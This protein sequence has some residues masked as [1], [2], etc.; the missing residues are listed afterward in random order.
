MDFV[1]LG[2]LQ[3]LDEGR[4]VT[5]AGSKRR[6]L[7][8]LLL[9]HANETVSTERL[10]DELWAER[11]P[12]T[13]ARTL[14]AHISRLRKALKAGAADPDG[15]IVTRESGY[16]L[17]LDPERL[18]AYQFERLVD[19]GRNELASGRA[20]RAVSGYEAALS[21]WR[22]T[23]LADFAS[24]QFAQGEIARLEDLRMAAI[25]GL[26]DAKLALGR[27]AELVGQLESLIGENP[28]RERLRAQLMLALYRCER[29]ADAL[30]AYQ[31]ARRTLVEDLGIEPGE[32]LRDLEHA[33]LSQDPAL[34][35]AVAETAE[36]AAARVPP[37]PNRTLGRDQ[38]REEVR[39][40]LRRDDRRLVTLVGPGGVGKTRLA[41]EAARRLEPD[42]RDGAW[43]VSLASTANPEHVPSA[44]AQTLGAT[45]LEGETPEQAIERFL[46]PKDALLVL[47]NFEHVLPAAPLITELLAAAP[48][49][50]VLATSREPLRLQTEYCYAVAPLEVPADTDPAAVTH[51]AAG[52]L[53]V[54]RAGS[55]DR[56]FELNPGNAG[57]IAEI[58]QRLDGLPLAI[59]LAAAR[60]TVLAPED[61][62]ARLEG[63]LDLLGHGPR[64]AP[65]RQRTLRATIEWSHDLLSAAESEAFAGL[66]VFAGGATTDAA[67]TITGAE[68]EAL[69]GLIDKQLLVRRHGAGGDARLWMLETVREF[70]REQLEADP[71]AD[72]V[73]HS[74]C[75]YYLALAERAEPHLFTRREDE[76]L[77]KLDAEG[78]NF[79]AA[80][81]WSIRHG[82]PNHGLQLAGL[83]GRYWDVRNLAPEGLD[84]LEAAIA[85]AGDEA[86][87]RDRALARRAQ[88]HLLVDQGAAYDTHDLHDDAKSKAAEALALSREAAEPAGVTD[89]LLAMASLDMAESHPQRRRRALANE[90]LAYARVAA[91]ERFV[92]LA[93]M[94]QANAISL[95][96]AAEEIE[97]ATT[98]LRKLGCSRILVAHYNNTAYNAIKVGRPER[99]RAF[100][101]EA[102]PLAHEVGFPVFVALTSGNEALEALFTGD[103]D[104]AR[105][106]FEEELRVCREHVVHQFV[107]EGLGGLAAVATHGNDLERAALL[108][109]AAKATGSGVGD[110]DVTGQFEERFFAPARAA[111]GTREWD[112]VQARG[113]QM[114]LEEAIAF[115][116][117]ESGA[118]G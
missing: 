57:A 36:S 35:V 107:G 118:P 50:T 53:F 13:A 100:L 28:Y 69:H 55:H 15:E 84:W 102:A 110:A 114:S 66:A 87:I 42:L 6:A 88:V 1:I 41:L 60:T 95:E 14:Q 97:Q 27:H 76:W 39:A 44:I 24:E 106:A 96:S 26:G 108:L 112:E 46:A 63:A 78:D 103:P 64:D 8:A 2:P 54:G 51:A 116:L 72:E 83:L 59:E 93:L 73:R 12:A 18:D 30:Q 20:D 91:E 45:P 21:L 37:P 105:A 111:H 56:A 75:R 80:L 31:N 70:A 9:L 40:L 94:E 89:A 115:A 81:D 11:P 7:L 47:D 61:L 98:A 85:T 33:I 17:T 68:I 32:R 77:P 67:Q 10:V 22:G 3:A 74:H 4:D 38:D 19:E 48:A 104:R 79:R 117:N 34:A 52:A 101:A 49:L 25:E 92:A 43:F 58:C 71:H 90:A 23:P 16:A 109:G 62:A 5:P 113:S 99:A 86:R 82:D 29:Q 65:A